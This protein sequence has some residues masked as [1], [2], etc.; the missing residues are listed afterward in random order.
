MQRLYL[1][2]CLRPCEEE[3]GSA[4]LEVSLVLRLAEEDEVTAVVVAV[5]PCCKGGG[6]C[7]VS[8]LTTEGL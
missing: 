4:V 6:C 1:F 7:L 8:L 5:G 2:D 3:V